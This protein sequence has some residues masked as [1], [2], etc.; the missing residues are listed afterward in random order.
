MTAYRVVVTRETT[1]LVACAKDQH[2]AAEFARKLAGYDRWG[3]HKDWA[4][5]EADVVTTVAEPC[6]DPS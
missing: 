4:S 1:V 5:V 2:E 3:P 6:E